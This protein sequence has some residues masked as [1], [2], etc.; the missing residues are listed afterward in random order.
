[1]TLSAEIKPSGRP[2]NPFIEESWPMKLPATSSRAPIWRTC[3]HDK[4]C[5]SPWSLEDARCI[6]ARIL[7][8]PHA[9]VPEQGLN[10][11]HFDAFL[12]HF[13]AALEEVSADKAHKVMKFLEGTRG[14]VLNR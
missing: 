12:K 14:E 5:L 11:T 3:L 10:D 8:P 13:R 7:V 2:Q 1:M 9:Q 4:V 6:K